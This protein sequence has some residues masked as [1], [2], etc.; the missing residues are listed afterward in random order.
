[1]GI[2]QNFLIRLLCRGTDRMQ[3]CKKIIFV[4]EPDFESEMSGQ[5]IWKDSLCKGLKESILGYFRHEYG[6]I[7]LDSNLIFPKQ[8]IF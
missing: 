3:T 5:L 6:E 1:M 8:I 2:E 7:G 4:Q